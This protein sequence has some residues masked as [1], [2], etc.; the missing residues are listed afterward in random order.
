MGSIV[1][2]IMKERLK[3]SIWSVVILALLVDTCAPALLHSR[4]KRQDLGNV[5]HNFLQADDQAQL[6]YVRHGL[7][8][9]QQ[10]V[11]TSLGQ[12]VEID[13]A[14]D[15]VFVASVQSLIT[16]LQS[17]LNDPSSTPSA[18]SSLATDPANILT[19]ITVVVATAFAAQIS[20]FTLFGD[21]GSES[22][23][24]LL[25]MILD[26]FTSVMEG[27]NNGEEDMEE[28]SNDMEMNG[29]DGSMEGEDNMSDNTD[30]GSGS[31][32][33]MESTDDMMD[34][35]MNEEE[36][37]GGIIEA[38]IAFITGIFG[39]DNSSN[40]TSEDGDMMSEEGSGDMS[41]SEG[42]G[43]DGMRDEDAMINIESDGGSS[44][45]GLSISLHPIDLAAMFVQVQQAIGMNCTCADGAMAE[46]MV[47]NATLRLIENEQMKKKRKLKK[48]VQKTEKK[49]NKRNKKFKK[50]N[51]KRVPKDIFV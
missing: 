5:V 17:I 48:I 38:V 1:R 45:G 10:G 2:D 34:E 6:E 18:L 25:G 51:G 39:G 50:V 9:L 31:G 14:Q 43:M 16:A 41:E 42:S 11:D 49:K 32:D 44:F 36:S 21:P 33:G 20:A 24:G 40:D 28:G 37:Q 27:M 46:E 26:L 4:T 15:R 8:L 3:K 13:Q 22:S 7:D 30:D 23:R 29:E 35:D 19:L 47:T 12:L